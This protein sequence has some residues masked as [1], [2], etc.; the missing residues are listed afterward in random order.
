MTYSGRVAWNVVGTT[1]FEKWFL[2]LAETDRARVADRVD[3]LEELGPALGRPTVDTI[4]A[5]RHHNM[6]ELRSGSLRILFVFDPASSAVLLLG[7]NKQDQW[8]NWYNTTIPAAD[9]IYDHYLTE[10]GQ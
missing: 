4:K 8:S 3:L 2:D 10:T 9:D 6:K 5:S 1:E 7:G